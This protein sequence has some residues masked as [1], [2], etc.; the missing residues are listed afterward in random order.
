MMAAA[1]ESAFLPRVSLFSTGLSA[2]PL[3]LPP[4][5]VTGPPGV[6]GER[7][8]REKFTLLAF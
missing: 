5:K 8:S 3:L 6:E 4:D 1:V 2:T 7:S